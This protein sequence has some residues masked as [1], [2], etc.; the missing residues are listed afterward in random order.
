V[1]VLIT[2]ATGFIGAE[3]A[4]QLAAEGH[5][6]R[7]AV[8]RPSRAALLGTLDAEVVF[9]DL[10]APDSLRRAVAG[11]DAVLHLGGRATF[12]PAR[13]LV[14]TF[15]HGTRALAEA[16]AEAGV[17]RFVFASSLLVHG[18]TDEPIGAL[19]T[20]DPV[21]DYG[22]VKLSVEGWLARYGEASGMSVAS[23]RLPHVYGATDLLFGR[24]RGGWL[25][26]PGRGSAPYGH[27]H[28][29]DAARVLVAASRSEWEG[30]SA[31]ADRESVGWDVFLGHVAELMP[32]LHTL[33]VPAPLAWA[34][35]TALSAATAW[36]DAPSLYTP[37]TVISWNLSLPVDPDALWDELGL[38]PELPTYRE[39]I[40]ATLDDCVA[41]RWRHPVQ[42]R[43]VA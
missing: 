25:V 6:P 39:G 11:C 8:R 13:R 41:F 42:D 22:R 7:L 18:P 27:L 24:I 16:A 37:D 35:T 23:I 33:R 32:D 28:V 15:V 36:R 43:R 14:D 34:G 26:V 21:V 2:G 10:R 3:V 38:E 12:E 20:P 1:K 31:I 30:A 5:Q 9:A 17:R 40:A 19:T 4:R 29:R